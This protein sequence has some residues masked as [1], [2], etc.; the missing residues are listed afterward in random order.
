[1]SSRKVYSTPRRTVHNRPLLSSFRRRGLC[2]ALAGM[3]AAVFA[4]RTEPRTALVIGN[5][6][7]A[8]GAE[9]PNAERDADAMADTLKDLGFRVLHYE[10]LDQRGMEE[11]VKTFAE[12]LRRAGGAGLF[13]YSGH[14]FQAG[15][16]SYL[17]P[18]GVRIDSET[19]A[20]FKT[21]DVE[22]VLGEMEEAGSRMNIVILDACRDNPFTRSFRRRG[23]EQLRGLSR[24]DAPVGTLIAY[25]TSPGKT[26]LDGRG[27]HSPYTGALL[28][29]MKKPGLPL[30]QAFK[31]V[32]IQ[33]AR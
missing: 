30:E 2:L 20:R 12:R 26:A 33:V 5:S 31:E 13:Y 29:V 28:E 24:V 11:A 10:D 19:D 32:R 1:M 27:K 8:D 16:H 18:I 7:Y 4:A 14:G 6:D 17:A 21:V 9:L 3:V 23:G 25:A 22:Y 15:G